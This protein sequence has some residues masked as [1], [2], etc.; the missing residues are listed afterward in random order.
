MNEWIV[1]PTETSR[2]GKTKEFNENIMDNVEKRIEICLIM[3]GY[4][5]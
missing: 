3:H 4:D 2:G 5:V 1:S